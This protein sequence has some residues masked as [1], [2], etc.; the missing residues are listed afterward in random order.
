MREQTT[1]FPDDLL[2]V[3]T[4]VYLPHAQSGQVTVDE[5]IGYFGQITL[6]N[7]KHV[8]VPND[9]Q[10]NTA[11]LERGMDGYTGW[12]ADEFFLSREEAQAMAKTYPL[13][14][15]QET[16]KKAIGYDSDCREYWCSN[17]DESELDNCCATTTNIR[18]LLAQAIFNCSLSA[19]GRRNLEQ[20]LRQHRKPLEY[21]AID[22]ILQ[23]LD[24][25]W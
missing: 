20:M 21:E 5:I 14:V 16:A 12:K 8:F 2:P 17:M 13:V 9:Y 1:N 15:D 4:K 25:K 18:W 24:L 22:S 6:Q 19:I 10:L 7:D 3:G 23:Q 11:N